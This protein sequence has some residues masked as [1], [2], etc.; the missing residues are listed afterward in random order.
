MLFWGIPFISSTDSVSKFEGIMLNAHYVDVSV[1]NNDLL[2]WYAAIVAALH[3][4]VSQV[5]VK[6]NHMCVYIVSLCIV[7]WL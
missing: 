2:H 6:Y 4:L 5:V 3:Q 1:V 7:Y